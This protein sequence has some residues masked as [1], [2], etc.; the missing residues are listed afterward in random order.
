MTRAKIVWGPQ[1]EEEWVNV[2]NFMNSNFRAADKC[3]I[4]SAMK[5]VM[6]WYSIKTR[7]VRCM[8]CFTPEG[9]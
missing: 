6:V 7:E 2:R 1:G 9:Y 4:C 5:C 8:K 3:S